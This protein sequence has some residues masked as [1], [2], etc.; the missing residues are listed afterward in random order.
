MTRQIIA[1]LIAAVAAPTPGHSQAAASQQDNGAGKC[2]IDSAA[3]RRSGVLTLWFVP[4]RELTDMSTN[5]VMERALIT[6]MQE[7]FRAPATVICGPGRGR[8]SR[9]ALGSSRSAASFASRSGMA[10]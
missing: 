9:K 5:A 6:E 1:I 4:S 2:V 7:T 8:G 10:R 3:A